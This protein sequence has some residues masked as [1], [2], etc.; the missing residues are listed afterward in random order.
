MKVD[1]RQDT[2]IVTNDGDKEVNLMVLDAIGGNLQEFLVDPADAGIMEVFQHGQQFTCVCFCFTSPCCESVQN[3]LRS[4]C[5]VVCV[6]FELLLVM[7]FCEL[8]C[9]ACLR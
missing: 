4:T 9:F 7:V 1:I 5:F 2:Y 3:G 6:I 8:V